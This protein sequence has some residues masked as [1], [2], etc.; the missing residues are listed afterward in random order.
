M[1]IIELSIRFGRDIHYQNVPAVAVETTS[2][3]AWSAYILQ[4]AVLLLGTEI[5]GAF[6]H[7]SAAVLAPFFDVKKV[8]SAKN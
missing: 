8:I 6:F 2:M 4:A 5:F 7:F 1:F 3:C